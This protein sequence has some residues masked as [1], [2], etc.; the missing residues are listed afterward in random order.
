MKSLILCLVAILSSFAQAQPCNTCP[1]AGTCI[2]GCAPGNRN[3]ASIKS[4]LAGWIRG[5]PTPFYGVSI[6]NNCY[7]D[8][9]ESYQDQESQIN[10]I[11]DNNSCQ[12]TEEQLT[13]LSCMPEVWNPMTEQCVSYE[14]IYWDK[15]CGTR[16]HSNGYCVSSECAQ[17]M[18]DGIIS[19]MDDQYKAFWNQYRLCLWQQYHY[20]ITLDHNQSGTVTAA[21][22]DDFLTDWANGDLAAD[23]N[24]DGSVDGG[25]LEQFYD[26]SA[27]CVVPW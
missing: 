8:M 11:V 22:E 13:R 17:V 3:R 7:T 4:E 24:N 10:F 18:I 15:Y 23:Y 26:M 14:I 20:C 16:D 9:C 5:C 6:Y 27:E 2:P 19:A 1:Q 25:D 21:D 12:P